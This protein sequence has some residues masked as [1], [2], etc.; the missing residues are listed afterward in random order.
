MRETLLT[1]TMILKWRVNL[2]WRSVKHFVKQ[3]VIATGGPGTWIQLNAMPKVAI[4]SIEKKET[5]LY[6]GQSMLAPQNMVIN[7]VLVLSLVTKPLNFFL[8]SETCYEC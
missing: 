4:P 7:L 1:P 8:V 5:I 2:Q 6:Q 3:L